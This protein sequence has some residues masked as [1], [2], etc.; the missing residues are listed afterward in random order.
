MREDNIQRWLEDFIIAHN[1]CPF[2]KRPFVQNQIRIRVVEDKE[3]VKLTQA[4]LE[5]LQ[6]LTAQKREV[7]ETTLLGHPHLFTDFRDFL[8][9]LS[10]TEE[11]LEEAG[12]TG[13]IQ[14][15]GFHPD[16]QF[17][18]E[19]EDDLAHFTNRSPFPLIHL[20]REESVSEAVDQHPAIG[21]IPERN[22]Q[23]LRKMDFKTLEEL[24]TGKQ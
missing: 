4:L 12:L 17:A 21:E 2:A 1:L 22:I 11:L 15:V 16:Y 10:W 13:V 19:A 3:E 14:L 23:Y 9:Y 8:D 20:L 24:R 6:H 18:G 5:E 7:V